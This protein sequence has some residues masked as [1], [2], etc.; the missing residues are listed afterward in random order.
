M[1]FW[2]VAALFALAV[3]GGIAL[4]LVRG[5][6]G[7]DGAE[8][9]D[10]QV[11]R[12]QLAEVDRDLARGVIGAEEAERARLEIKRRLL[13]ADRAARGRQR[14]GAAPRG[15]T[16]AA[17][18]LAVIVVT[19]GSLA[20]YR[21]LGAPG[22]PDLPLAERLAEAEKARA[23]RPRQA[24]ME[25]EIGR[26][27]PPLAGLDPRYAEL[28]EKLREVVAG[29]PDDL[30]GQIL[31]AQNEARIGN[32]GAAWRAQA[33][34][35][36]LKGESASPEDWLTLAELMIRA[37]N[38]YVSPEAEAALSRVLADDPHNPVARFY[39]GLMFAQN[40]RPDVTFRIWRPLL[41]ESAPNAPWAAP[42]RERITEIAADAG[43]RY[44]P[45]SAGGARP[46][47]TAE[48]IEAAG[49]MSVQERQAMIEGMVARLSDRLAS[50]GGPPEDWARLVTALGVLG[51]GEEAARIWSEAQEVFAG[52]T[53]ALATVRAAAE[54]AGVAQ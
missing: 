11:Y 20:A 50:E 13:E 32:Y 54:R 52:D 47:P 24:E 30:Q 8:A 49:Q 17:A 10:I 37:A 38:G 53:A 5:Q 36:E 1:I 28:M 42:I 4:A 9:T 18:A 2:T 14:A 44:S 23:E 31:L 48:D 51:R 34:V 41:E 26:T 22:Y 7:E 29:R 39:S 3:A 40:G 15:A 16:L 46:G 21:Y 12:D 35:I 27:P 25:A 19:A 6:S 43:I 33:K 45:P